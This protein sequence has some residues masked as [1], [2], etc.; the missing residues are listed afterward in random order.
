MYHT[1]STMLLMAN[2]SPGYV[3]KTM[4]VQLYFHLM[5]V[6][7][8]YMPGEGG[9]GL[10]EALSGLMNPP[11]VYQILVKIRIFAHIKKRVSVSY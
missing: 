8:H 5:D 3:Q 4:G 9:A 2:L 10:E 7:C 11:G 6:Y 1:Y